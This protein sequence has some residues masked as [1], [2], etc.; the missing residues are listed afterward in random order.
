M[1]IPRWIVS[2]AFA[3]LA[4]GAGPA[5]ADVTIIGNGLAAE[6]SAAARGVAA[7]APAR[8]D[9][10][11]ECTLAL[12]SEALS[13]HE[14]AATYVNRGVLRLTDGA[15]QA[16]LND[17]DQAL[18]IEPELAEAIVDRGAA[19]LAG[20][21]DA[22]AVAEITR[23]LVLN[24]T[25]PE[26]AYYNRA[27]AEERLGDVKS[28]YFDYLKAADLKPDWPLPRTELTRFKVSQP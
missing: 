28:A 27:L 2:T 18:R 24:P 22:E 19:L 23:G 1:A 11:H 16:A 17:F 5:W 7:N 25:Q 15:A 3:G 13:A 14:A 10:E 4:L 8:A 21:H 20:G 6:C 26:K 9:A 12:D